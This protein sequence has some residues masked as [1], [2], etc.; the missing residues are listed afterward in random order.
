MIKLKRYSGDP[1]FA[2]KKDNLW[3]AASVFN[4]AA[5]YDNGLVHMVYRATDISSG[6]TEG[7]YINALGCLTGRN[8]SILI[9]TAPGQNESLVKLILRFSSSYTKPAPH[10]LGH[11]GTFDVIIVVHII[12][13]IGQR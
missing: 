4:A 11:L 1:V 12:V 8:H 6:G 3:E 7:P 13:E 2:P 5:I 9:T 10:K